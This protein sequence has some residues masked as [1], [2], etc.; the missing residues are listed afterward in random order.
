MKIHEGTIIGKGSTLATMQKVGETA[1]AFIVKF[2]QGDLEL[3]TA[4]L[5]KSQVKYENG[6]FE[7]PEWL[8]K[9]L[10]ISDY[11]DVIK[12]CAEVRPEWLDEILVAIERIVS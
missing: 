8:C 10:L 2:K 5:P 4:F 12:N 7:I 6:V 9:K 3:D 1:K 11:V